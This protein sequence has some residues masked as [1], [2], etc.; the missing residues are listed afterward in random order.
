MRFHVLI[1]CGQACIVAERRKKTKQKQIFEM[2]KEAI[3]TNSFTEGKKNMK[4]RKQT[5]NYSNLDDK[6]MKKKL[7]Q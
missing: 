4:K 3:E 6:L 5:A 1:I 7:C 2:M